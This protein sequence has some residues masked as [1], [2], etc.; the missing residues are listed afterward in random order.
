MI[1]LRTKPGTNSKTQQKARMCENRTCLEYSKYVNQSASIS[2]THKDARDSGPW[3]K[4]A[5]AVDST[6]KVSPLHIHPPPLDCT[7]L[8][9]SLHLIVFA[10]DCSSLLCSPHL[11]FF[12]FDCSSLPLFHLLIFL[13]YQAY[14]LHLIIFALDDLLYGRDSLCICELA[15]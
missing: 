6:L 4:R 7:S 12:A 8:P 10:S 1:N 11:I 5:L 3:H 2:Y 15:E 14:S 13:V 9:S